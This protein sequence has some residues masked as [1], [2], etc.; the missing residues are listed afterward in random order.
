MLRKKFRTGEV[1]LTTNFRKAFR[2]ACAK[3]GLG[4]KTGSKE[5]HYD[6]LLPYDL[7]RSAARNLKRAGVDDDTIMKITGHLTK[8]MITR[9]NIVDVNDVKKAMKQ[10]ERHNASLIQVA[11][12]QGRRK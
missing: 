5:W 1:F 10:V 8:D 7:R 9:Y 11:Q 2:A 3:V 4:K 6:G 12:K